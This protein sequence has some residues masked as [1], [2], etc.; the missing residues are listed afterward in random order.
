MA[1]PQ[2]AGKNSSLALARR[3]GQCRQGSFQ[4]PHLLHPESENERSG[5]RAGSGRLFRLA[6]TPGEMAKLPVRYWKRLNGILVAFGQE[7]ANPFHLFAPAAAYALPAIGSGSP[8]ADDGFFAKDTTIFLL[9]FLF[10]LEVH[11]PALF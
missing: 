1:G 9:Y 4:G 3:D 6:S 11:L 8:A 7:Y 10:P 2:E 5:D